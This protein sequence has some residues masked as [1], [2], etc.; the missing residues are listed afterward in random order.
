[1]RCAAGVVGNGK[2]LAQGKPTAFIVGRMHIGWD[3]IIFP[4]YYYSS[5]T[6]IKFYWYYCLYTITI[7]LLYTHIIYIQC[8]IYPYQQEI[9]IYAWLSVFMASLITPTM[10]L[11]RGKRWLPFCSYLKLKFSTRRELLTPAS[12]WLTMDSSRER[13]DRR[14]NGRTD[15]WLA[16]RW[17][18]VS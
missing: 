2:Y 12:W 6:I 3:A 18:S 15:G 8:I 1:M 16:G 14:T 10:A 13:M 9:L 5:T 17:R 11:L 7:L 4:I